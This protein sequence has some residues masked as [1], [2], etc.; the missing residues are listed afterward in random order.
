[1]KP[2]KKG[3]RKKTASY[4]RL[5]TASFE[6]VVVDRWSKEA[7]LEYVL[8]ATHISI[9]VP[10]GSSAGERIRI[11]AEGTNPPI[12]I[13]SL[14]EELEWYTVPR[15]YTAFG[16]PGPHI[17]QIAASHGL[18]WWI[19]ERGLTVV[20]VDPGS[21]LS[22]FDSA[23]GKLMVEHWANGR[24]AKDAD[25][26]IAAAADEKGFQLKDHLRPKFYNDLAKYNQEYPKQAIKTFRA[27]LKHHLTRRGVRL[28]FTQARTRFLSSEA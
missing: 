1:M 7:A 5:L 16:L 28:R 18:H 19:D 22:D 8:N 27:A 26:I 11:I 9:G 25:A 21:N 17:D 13:A 3:S 24:L 4:K 6:N 15:G 10:S 12:P 23:V 2:K 14:S 20:R